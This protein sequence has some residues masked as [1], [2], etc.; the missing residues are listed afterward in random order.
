MLEIALLTRAKDAIVD[1][2]E[3]LE[4]K[5]TPPYISKIL[6]DCLEILPQRR[7]KFSAV[8]AALEER[9]Q[10]IM[11]FKPEELETAAKKAQ[12]EADRKMMERLNTQE[13]KQPR[14][15]VPAVVVAVEGLTG[16]GGVNAAAT[17]NAE[18]DTRKMKSS[19]P[20][21]F[22]LLGNR[23]ELKAILKSK[24]IMILCVIFS[25]LLVAICVTVAIMVSKFSSSTSSSTSSFVS[26]TPSSS[27][28][29]SS[30]TASIAI[31]LSSKTMWGGANSYFIYAL[32]RSDQSSILTSLVAA[33]IKIIRIYISLV[34]PGQKKSSSIFIP[35]VEPVTL[36][37]FDDTILKSIDNFLKLAHDNSIKV[38]ISPHDRN[39]LGRF[40]EQD[41][42]AT[43]F[44]L[45]SS[46]ASSFYSNPT[47]V[48][49]YQARIAHI[50]NYKSS[51]FSNRPWGSLGEVIYA[52]DVQSEPQAYD[53]SFISGWTCSMASM[54]KPLLSNGVLVA[55]GGG[56]DFSD[57]LSTEYFQCSSLDIVAFHSISNIVGSIQDGLS[58]AYSLSISNNKLIVFEAFGY[59]HN[60]KSGFFQQVLATCTQLGIP[61]VVWEVMIPN[62]YADYEMFIQ[63]STTWQIISD[64]ATLALRNNTAG[65]IW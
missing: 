6:G 53:T 47:I 64:S 50:L 12:L 22:K 24:R 46:D 10:D 60:P 41:I 58:D 3:K 49:A 19:K 43:T 15:T 59:A 34:V 55:S 2:N 52:F 31:G 30:S 8:N 51:S 65:S 21:V 61:W 36:G 13:R 28:N 16:V 26:P 45:P 38:I 42:Y 27:T 29:T 20:A 32:S 17:A 4:K 7:P 44:K 1:F 33:N 11:T 35:D 37:V 25:L 56:A 18:L 14:E 57:S 9:R 63:D 5:F 23:N 54:M 40:V 39:A 48:A 62:N